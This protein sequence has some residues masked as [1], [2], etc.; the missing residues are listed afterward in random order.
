VKLEFQRRILCTTYIYFNFCKTWVP[1]LSG[2]RCS[3]VSEQE[4]Q[5]SVLISACISGQKLKS[6]SCGL[7]QT[8]Q[9][10]YVAVKHSNWKPGY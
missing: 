6:I 7:L 2:S 1:R 5:Y 10:F 8:S 9:M 3:T 4:L